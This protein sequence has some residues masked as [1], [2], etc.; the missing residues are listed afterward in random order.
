[1]DQKLNEF[2]VRLEKKKMLDDAVVLLFA[3]HG[4]HM[5][6]P[7]YILNLDG[8][9]NEIALPAMFLSLPQSFDKEL[10]ANVEKN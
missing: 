1:M 6:G 8:V 10:L 9:N 5:Q 7:L 3:D 2:L 4:L